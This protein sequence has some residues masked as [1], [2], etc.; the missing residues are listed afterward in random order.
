MKHLYTTLLLFGLISISSSLFAQKVRN[1][2]HT[3]HDDEIH[4]HYDIEDATYKN[5]YSVVVGIS[6][7][8][9]PYDYQM[10]KSIRGDIG[11]LE[12]PGKG[13]TIIWEVFKDR[14]GLEGR[15]SFE[16]KLTEEKVKLPTY[17]AIMIS[18]TNSAPFGLKYARLGGVGFYLG[19][20]ANKEVPVAHTYEVAADGMIENYVEEGYYVIGGNKKLVSYAGT[21]GLTFQLSKNAFMYAGGGYGAEQLFWEYTDYNFPDIK[22]GDNWAL[23]QAV[24]NVGYVVE[25]GFTLKM[26]AFVLEIGGSTIAMKSFQGNAGIGFAF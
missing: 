8:G 12:S 6:I 15:V 21:A 11:Q 3:I 1:I 25:T 10:M 23:N 9:S 2:N 19:V 17:N 26:G 14:N 16:I 18:G 22:M 7:N 4:L 5:Q 20:R 13:H 24:N